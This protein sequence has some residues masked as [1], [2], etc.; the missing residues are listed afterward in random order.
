MI[1]WI[2]RLRTGLPNTLRKSHAT[3]CWHLMN[4][5]LLCKAHVWCHIIRTIASHPCLNWYIKWS[6]SYVL[7]WIRFEAAKWTFPKTSK[8]KASHIVH[9]SEPVFKT[10]ALQAIALN[11]L[12]FTTTGKTP[13]SG[14][15]RQEILTNILCARLRLRSSK[16]LQ[17]LRQK[18]LDTNLLLSIAY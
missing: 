7:V 11:E 15:S 5:I 10:R 6:R 16:N 9:L 1:C 14:F 18:H 2:F 4:S 17:R 13:V 12:V 3:A 8:N